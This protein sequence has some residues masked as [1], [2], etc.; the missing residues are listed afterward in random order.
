M[1]DKFRAIEIKLSRCIVCDSYNNPDTD[2]TSND[3]LY[4]N[5]PVHIAN[6][7]VVSEYETECKYHYYT[8]GNFVEG[9]GLLKR[10]VYK[11]NLPLQD[12]EDEDDKEFDGGLETA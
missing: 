11:Y 3:Q 8:N 12:A 4:D 5:L 9:N 7:T 10:M 1:V 2:F 6:G